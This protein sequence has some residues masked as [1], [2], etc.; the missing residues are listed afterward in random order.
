MIKCLLS[1]VWKE[2][3]IGFIEIF[4]FHFLMDLHI[5]G[6]PEHDLSVTGKCLSMCLCDWLCV[7]NKIL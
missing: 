3:S 2:D 7:F 4:D 1:S 6:Y 5:L